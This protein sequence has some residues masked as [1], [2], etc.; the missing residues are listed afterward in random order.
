MGFR[1]YGIWSRGVSI[2]FP[3]FKP[4]KTRV[5]LM[6]SYLLSPLD[7][8]SRVYVRGFNASGVGSLEF[9]SGFRVDGLGFRMFASIPG[10]VV[11]P[12]TFRFNLSALAGVFKPPSLNLKLKTP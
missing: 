5:A 3:L 9:G 10:V 2:I 4:E 12:A 7:L 6:L 1:A 8:P 11:S